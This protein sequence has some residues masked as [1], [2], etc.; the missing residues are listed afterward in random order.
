MRSGRVVLSSLTLAS[1]VTLAQ[2]R[3]PAASTLAVA[4]AKATITYLEARPVIEALHDVLPSDL[5]SKTPPQLESLW[6]AWVSRRNGEIRARLERG[7]EDSVVNFWLYGT[8]FTKLPRATERDLSALADQANPADIVQRRLED[9][10]AALAVPGGDERLRFAR[11]VVERHG[12]DPSTSAGREGLR[13]YLIDARRRIVGEFQAYDRT[14]Q[15]ALKSDPNAGVTAYAT[16]FR[17]RGLSAD[18]S[19]LPDYG[20]ERALEAIRSQGTLGAGSVRRIG[21]VGPGLDFTNKADGYDFYPQQTIQPFAVID[22][23]VRHGL[24]KPDDVRVT[25]FDL[26]PRINEHLEAA[27]QRA[28]LGAPYVVQL[29]MN[30]DEPWASDLV[31]YWRRFGDRIGGGTKAAPPPAGAGNVGVRAVR[32]RP[33]FVLATTPLDL[34]IVLERLDLPGDERFDLIVATNILV[35]YDLFEQ[36]LALANVSRMLRPGGVFLANNA[37]FPTAPMK[38]SA[39]YLQVVYSDRQHDHMFWYQHE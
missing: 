31:T 1:A 6:S 13:R 34:N 19:L 25:T 23:L 32:V 3:Q 7:D 36:A 5:A 10:I 18:T 38:P 22:S 33:Q 15:S 14:V 17:D 2:A 27:H 11:Q 8:T 9:L 12:L 39:G 37:A 4:G 30:K 28:R 16:I 20:I 24:A 29:P 21:I 35:Y 26:S